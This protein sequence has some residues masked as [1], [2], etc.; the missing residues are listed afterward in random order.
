LGLAWGWCL[1]LGL[2]GDW[3]LWLGLAWCQ[4][5]LSI[6]LGLGGSG[7]AFLSHGPLH[8]E[9]QTV[10]PGAG[11]SYRRRV[12]GLLFCC[13]RTEPAQIAQGAIGRT[14]TATDSHA[15]SLHHAS[16]ST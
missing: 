9:D 4:C 16:N 15:H 14:I 7:D 5:W 11:R 1:W 3:Y 6:A 12:D 13:H 8:V 2:A 10:K